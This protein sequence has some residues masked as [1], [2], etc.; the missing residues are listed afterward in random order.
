M[1]LI[2]AAVAGVIAGV[3]QEPWGVLAVV[4]LG[5]SGFVLLMLGYAYPATTEAGERV[6][7]DWRAYQA[8][9]KQLGRDPSRPLDLDAV[10]PDAVA[11]GIIA[12]LDRRLKEASKSGYAP[13]WFVRQMTADSSVAFYPVWIA[14]HGSASPSS[15]SGGGGASSGGGGA[16]GGF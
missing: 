7:A 4:L 11:L 16:G 6:A 9:L 2:A 3:G 13:A 8:G 1:A 10:L 5:V 15:S 14:F 12:A